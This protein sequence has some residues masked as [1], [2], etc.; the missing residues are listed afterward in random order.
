[1]MRFYLGFIDKNRD[2]LLHGDFRA[3][4]LAFDYTSASAARDGREIVS[5]YSGKTA[6]IRVGMNE[7][8]IVNVTANKEL[9]IE[10]AE[11]AKYRYTVKNCMGDTIAL[12]DADFSCGFVRL[13]CTQN[14]M[15]V[16]EK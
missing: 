1:M 15:I 7:A 8:V 11:P 12:G 10:C 16:F 5:V 6:E 14:G 2:V 4:G 9:Y 13:P 3:K